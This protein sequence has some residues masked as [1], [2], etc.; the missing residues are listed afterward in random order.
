METAQ[1]KINLFLANWGIHQSVHLRAEII[2]GSKR[3]VA[4]PDAQFEWSDC[5]TYLWLSVEG[6][7]GGTDS[8]CGT[9]SNDYND[10]LGEWWYFD[11]L[12][13]AP[14]FRPEH[15]AILRKAKA[16]DRKW[17]FRRSAGQPAIINL[18]Y[19]FIAG[20]LAEL[21][22]GLVFSSD[23]AWDYQRLPISGA[24]FL[25]AYFN[26]RAATTPEERAWVGQ[27]INI[28]R[29]EIHG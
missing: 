17:S 25:A 20:A 16:L 14:N 12:R 1:G 26:L 10:G 18:G 29:S 22:D 3:V 19:G 9:I 27:N 13:R 6:V 5:D 23:N 7:A 24:D 2:T 8:Y 15:E 11:M 4:K 28:L 21:T